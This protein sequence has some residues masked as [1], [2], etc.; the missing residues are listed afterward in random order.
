MKTEFLKGLGLDDDTVQKIFAENGKD[1]KRE[2]EKT[3]DLQQKL[4]T[5]QKQIDEMSETVKTATGMDETIKMLQEKILNYERAE[6][7]RKQTEQAAES[8]ARLKA[9]FEP[10]RGTNN[11]LNEGTEKWIFSEFEKAI[12]D[13]SNE[14]KSDAEIYTAIT[15]DKNI[16]VNPQEPFMV[17]P[18]SNKQKITNGVEEAFLKRNPNL[19]I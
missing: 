3:L 10:L 8:M 15:K 7:Q 17:P 2:Q 5:A 4:D 13:K 1:I 19:K 9:R 11:F 12:A 16:Y 18:A 6:E 14:G